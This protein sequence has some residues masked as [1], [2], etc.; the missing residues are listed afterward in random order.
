VL[1]KVYGNGWDKLNMHEEHDQHESLGLILFSGKRNA[2][3]H[4]KARSIEKPQILYKFLVNGERDILEGKY[5][6]MDDA[7]MAILRLLTG[8]SR[9]DSWMMGKEM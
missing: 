9:R 5:D 3:I 4:P 7:R 2:I 1:A 8:L 6:F